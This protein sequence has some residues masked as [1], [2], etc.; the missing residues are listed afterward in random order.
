MTLIRIRE[1]IGG[2][3]GSNAM[4]S[5]D[6]GPEYPITISDPFTEE[7]E[8][9]LEWYFEEHLEF[10]FTK[11]V[12]AQN[13]AASITTYGETLFKQVFGTT[14]IYAEY[15]SLL[16]A[17][18]NNLQ[19]EIVGSPNLH[20]LHWEAM[21]DPKL[22]QPLAL[23]A[24]MVRKNLRPQALPASIRPSPTIN[25]LI[26]TARPS[27]RRDVGYRTLSRPLVETTRATNLRV[28]VEILRPGTYRAL[29]NHLRDI[30]ATYGEGYYHMIHFDVHGAVLTYEQLQGQRAFNG[31]PHRFMRYAR[32]EIQPYEGVKAFLSFEPDTDDDDKA[33]KVDLVEASEL[34]SL[35][36]AHQVP[37]TILNAC[38]SGKQIGQR[39]TSL[40]SHLIQAGVQLVL[41]MG[42]SITVSAAELLMKTLYQHLF[43]DDLVIAIRHGR[44]A[45]YNHKERRAYFDQIIDLEDWLLP[46]VYQD[47][48]VTLQPR[49]F[50]VEESNAWYERKAEEERYTP[51]DPQYGFVGRDIDILQVEKRLLS[52]RNLLLIRG[53]GGAG[54][55]TLLRHLGAWWHITGFVQRVFYFGYD[56]K[57]WTVEQIMVEIAQQLYGADYTRAFQPLSSIAKAAKL[58]QDLRANNHLLILDNLESITGTHLAIQHTLPQGE[59]AALRSFLTTLTNGRTLVLLGS[60]GSEDWLA[61]GTFEANIYELPGLDPEAASILADRILEKHNATRYRENEDLIKLIRV[62][63]GFPLALEVVLANLARQTPT[64]VLAALEAGDVELDS[65]DGEL[66]PKSNF[67]QKTKSILRCI[68]YSHSNLSPEAQQLLLCLAPF[69]SVVWLDMFDEYTKHLRRQPVLAALPFDNWPG[70]FRETQDW[71]LLSPDPDIPGFMHLQPALPYFL[72]NRL[73]EPEQAS[74]RST[75]ENAFLRHYDQLAKDL[76]VVLESKEPEQRALE[77]SLKQ[78]PAW[79]EVQ[80]S[81]LSHDHYEGKG[82]PGKQA[83][84]IQRW[85]CQVA[86]SLKQE[87]MGE[88]E[89]R[90]A[91]FI[92]GTNIL[93]VGQLSDEEL[94]STYKQ[95]G[96]VER[97]FRFLK[98]PL[99]LASS[100]FVKKPER[101]VALGFIMVLCLLVYRFAEYRLRTRLAETAQTLPNQVNKPTSTPTMRLS[102]SNVLRGLTSCSSSRLLASPHAFSISCPFTIRF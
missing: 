94:I 21:K 87:R 91:C 71:G 31:N 46:V 42:Y 12:R 102:S 9:E 73:A 58:A 20:A 25:L 47:Q 90:R 11:K 65:K 34:A 35:L 15:R 67:E 5:F 72:R 39:E 92:V 62:L 49:E 86:L 26:V 55:T 29:V 22:S 97:G 38:Q 19:L 48:P 89:R 53:M 23:Q 28:R 30:S 4:V 27:G 10:P 50:T 70:M 16:K 14:D 59:Q 81:Y 82:R 6:N 64:E 68:D 75:V 95:Q 61:K 54:K 98:D 85:Q 74:M 33:R 63:D 77:G 8:R 36:V 1:R 101:I 44:I 2:P 13:A 43:D 79:F 18:L 83:V 93:E 100:V 60:R 99:F 96:S 7:E 51:P 40:G 45:L 66:Q 76:F 78:L 88:E 84:P 56:E 52:K 57:A 37:I 32:E 24:V 17:G 80:R 41:A 3:N 69:T